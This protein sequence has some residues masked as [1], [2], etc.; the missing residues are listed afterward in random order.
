MKTKIY[1]QKPVSNAGR[2][3]GAARV[4]SRRASSQL[5][6]EVIGVN[7]VSVSIALVQA[8][9]GCNLAVNCVR[10]GAGCGKKARRFGQGIGGL[11]VGNELAVDVTCD[12]R[13]G[14]DMTRPTPT[15]RQL[16]PISFCDHLLFQPLNRG[17][18]AA[19]AAVMVATSS[20]NAFAEG[21]RGALDSH[22]NFTSKT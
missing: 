7:I 19:A 12:R 1:N 18:A 16:P 13:L 22:F 9:V 14:L 11:G 2:N 8:I 5:S 4:R 3:A 15:N 21:T 17:G 20:M 10:S 6:I